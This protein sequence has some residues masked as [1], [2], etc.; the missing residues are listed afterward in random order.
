MRIRN[1]SDVLGI[2]DRNHTDP[3]EAYVHCHSPQVAKRPSSDAD[4]RGRC[5]V[6]TLEYKNSTWFKGERQQ[7]SVAMTR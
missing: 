2:A 7:P 4:W 5:D 3:I 6:P 1:F